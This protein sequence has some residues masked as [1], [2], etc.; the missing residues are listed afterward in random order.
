MSL[1]R[2]FGISTSALSAYQEAM[3]ISAD[4]I[5][6]AGNTSYT[7]QTATFSTRTTVDGMG[8][9]VDV[10]DVVRVRNSMLDAQI[11]KYQSSYSESSKR[12]SYLSQIES[13]VSEP[14]D[15]GLATYFTSFFNSWN[16]LTTTPNSTI[17]RAN[18]I[19]AAQELS[20]RFNGVMDGLTD[21][22]TTLQGD[23]TT[24]I[25]QINSYVKQIKDYNFEIYA[26]SA[27]N[28]S[29]ND[30]KD[31][32]DAAI[33]SLSQLVNTTVMYN[34][35]G[36]AIVSVGGIQ[37]A[38][39][40]NYTE[41]DLKMIDGQMNLVTKNAAGSIPIVNS[42]EFYA[43]SDLYSNVIPQYQESLTTLANNFIESVNAIHMTGYTLSESGVSDTGIPFFGELDADGNVVNTFSYGQM[44]INSQIID[45][46]SKIAASSVANNDGN[47]DIANKI[48]VLSDSQISNLGNKTVSDFYTTILNDL[49]TDKTTSDS[50]VESHNAVLTQLTAEKKSYSG[51]STDEEMTNVLQ[52]QR[53]YQAA[54]KMVSIADELLQTLINMV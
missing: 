30:L 5:S 49:G 1:S 12:S 28:I 29:A 9:G 41:F 50:K 16:E 11:R 14:S 40:S 15:T 42:G 45:D 54:A 43:I 17:Q 6:N 24:T 27:S 19:N 21:V 48:A 7:R 25:K 53:S 23:A 44:N 46:T 47:G 38:D 3:N 8:A 2:I 36:T 13:L 34:D 20:D 52:Y 26:A 22:Q 18:V 33:D 31:K 4:N 35:N 37:C 32:R 39:Q 10:S 51:V